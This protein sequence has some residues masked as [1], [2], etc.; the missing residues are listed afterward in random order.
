MDKIY[1]KSKNY[2]SLP[3]TLV[4]FAGHRLE[5]FLFCFCT[6]NCHLLLGEHL[7]TLTLSR[8]VSLSWAKFTKSCQLLTTGASMHRSTSCRFVKMCCTA[9]LTY[10]CSSIRRMC[11]SHCRRRALILRTTSNVV[12]ALLASSCWV[13][14]PA[15]QHSH[16]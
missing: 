16:L 1:R 13:Y 11:P 8:H 14:A 7:R 5:N 6:N 10:L 2:I 4:L 15:F 9:F 12:V 3:I